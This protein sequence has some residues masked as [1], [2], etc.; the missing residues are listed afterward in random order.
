MPDELQG[1]RLLLV[2]DEFP[3]LM[4]L[5]E[6]VMALGC[7][8]VAASSQ[9]VEAEAPAKSAEI[10]AAVLDVNVAGMRVYPVA[11]ALKERAIPF[12]FATGYG[13]SG[14]EPAW[15]QYQVLQKPFNERQLGEAITR[16]IA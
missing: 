3:I 10:D 2:E 12:V 13:R 1:L 14:V 8:V 16:A 11:T 9:V 4:L 15:Q 6:M 5:E 7:V